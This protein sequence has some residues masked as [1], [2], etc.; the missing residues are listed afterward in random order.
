MHSFSFNLI[1]GEYHNYKTHSHEYFS[2]RNLATDTDS[3]VSK[4]NQINTYWNLFM[5]CWNI[6]PMNIAIFQIANR[7][8]TKYTTFLNALQ[9]VKKLDQ[10]GA[11][12]ILNMIHLFNIILYYILS[13]C[14]YNTTT[15]SNDRYQ[16]AARS[17][18][19]SCIAYHCILN[20]F[21]TERVKTILSIA[22]KD[23]P[24]STIDKS[25]KPKI[26]LLPLKKRSDPEVDNVLKADQNAPTIMLFNSN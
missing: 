23:A 12:A 26:L 11:L 18:V 1:V 25:S 21:F 19:T 2:Y 24:S 7:K 16:L 15:F 17:L 4:W 20:Y 8:K 5:F 10:K 6:I 3:W 13:Y 14:F 22:L 9:N